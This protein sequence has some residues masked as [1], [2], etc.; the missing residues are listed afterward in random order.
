MM[1]ITFL[2][3]PVRSED[4]KTAERLGHLIEESYQ[5]L[6]YKLIYVPPA[7]IAERTEFVLAHL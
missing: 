2:T 4:E 3:D 1:R 6:G 5:S 7:G